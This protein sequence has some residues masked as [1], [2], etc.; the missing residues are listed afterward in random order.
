MPK[1]NSEREETLA[2][3][4]VLA[5]ILGG[6]SAVIS[7]P[8]FWVSPASAAAALAFGVVAGVWGLIVAKKYV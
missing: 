1:V 6:L 3:W 5:L 8:L 2:M 7:I 4:A